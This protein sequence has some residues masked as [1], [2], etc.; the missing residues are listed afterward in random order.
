MTSVN[1]LSD[2]L[3][4]DPYSFYAR[5]RDE[6]PVHPMRL[7]NGLDAWQVSR[8]ED[9][10]MVLADRRFSLSEEALRGAGLFQGNPSPFGPSLMTSDPP[11]HTRLRRL[12]SKAF[13]PR[14]VESLRPR[15]QEIV[16]GLLDAIAPL[17]EADLVEAFA[18]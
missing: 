16:D 4:A 8:Y 5:L 2:E 12:V 13:T 18:F 9:A 17:G 14:R 6:T 7:P 10:R 15:V 1:L 3:L 11:H